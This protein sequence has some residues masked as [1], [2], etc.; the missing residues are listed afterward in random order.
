MYTA[1]APHRKGELQSDSIAHDHPFDT[2]ARPYCPQHNPAPADQTQPK[3]VDFAK[4]LARRKLVNTGLTQFD[5]WL[6][7]FRAW[8]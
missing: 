8:H 7:S 4:Y 3:M 1:K 5:D 6:E 2:L